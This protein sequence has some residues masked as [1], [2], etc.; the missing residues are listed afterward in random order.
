M[1]DVSKAWCPLLFLPPTSARH[2]MDEVTHPH[3]HLCHPLT[4][5]RIVT[6]NRIGA[7]AEKKSE[8]SASRPAYPF[9]G[10]LPMSEFGGMYA[11]AFFG[12]RAGYTMFLGPFYIILCSPVIFCLLYIFYSPTHHTLRHKFPNV[13]TPPVIS[14]SIVIALIEKLGPAI[15]R[16]GYATYPLLF[17][18]S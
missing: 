2:R 1:G 15:T 16:P 13:Y 8:T 4:A 14:A 5:N 3:E 11:C 12:E 7:I 6:A 9:V 18:S 17:P 10:S